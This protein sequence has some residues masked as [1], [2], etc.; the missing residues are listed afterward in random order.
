MLKFCSAEKC[1]LFISTQAVAQMG[2]ATNISIGIVAGAHAT[3]LCAKTKIN[4]NTRAR[5]H[6]ATT[7]NKN[8][9]HRSR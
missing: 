4:K 7:K 5:T 8:D 1:Q 3:L 6:K 2:D 9:K